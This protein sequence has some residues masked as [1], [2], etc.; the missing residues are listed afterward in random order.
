MNIRQSTIKILIYFSI[1]GVLFY[2]VF[3]LLGKL[4]P[5]TQVITQQE[6]HHKSRLKMFESYIKQ[7]WNQ[8]LIGVSHFEYYTPPKE[9]INLG[10]AGDTTTGVLHRLKPLKIK[11]VKDFYILIG[12]NDVLSGYKLSD[13]KSN[14]LYI[15][16]ELAKRNIENT[17]LISLPPVA[18]ELPS[19]DLINNQVIE[20]NQYLKKLAK[21]RK[22]HF[23]DIYSDL[24]ENGYLNTLYTTDGLH[25]NSNGYEIV[26]KHLN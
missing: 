23:I 26:T 12:I 5:Q 1:A 8:V 17:Y 19:S 3:N 2:G 14:Y 13:I 21:D 7:D 9:F 4:S 20:L 11:T 16:E 25:L 22:I 10:I 6:K 15:I 24:A 18:K